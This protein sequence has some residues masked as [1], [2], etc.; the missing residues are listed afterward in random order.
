MRGTAV[1]FSDLPLDLGEVVSAPTY[2]G[3][4]GAWVVVLSQATMAEFFGCWPEL[5]NYPAYWQD[6][7]FYWVLPC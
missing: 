2:L 7:W 4:R 6:K 1:I 5:E 3:Q